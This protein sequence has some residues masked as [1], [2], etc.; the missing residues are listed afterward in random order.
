MVIGMV[1]SLA[2]QAGP[3]A[4]PT[5]PPTSQGGPTTGNSSGVGTA[6]NGS[7]AQAAR[8]QA[9]LAAA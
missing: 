4:D 5:R 6:R 7:T 2:A 3:L 8:A 9:A 1:A